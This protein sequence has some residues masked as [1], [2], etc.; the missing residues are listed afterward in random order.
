MNKYLLIGLLIFLKKAG[1]YNDIYPNISINQEKYRTVKK[2]YYG[3]HYSS[4]TGNVY[5][6]IIIALIQL[7]LNA[8]FIELVSA[9]L[10]IYI[11]QKMK[12]HEMQNETGVTYL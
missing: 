2:K 3:N 7:Y 1:I 5:K 9:G 4:L 8:E 10:W 11:G 12:F 6:F